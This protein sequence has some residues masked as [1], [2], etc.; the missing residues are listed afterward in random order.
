[1]MASKYSWSRSLAFP[2]CVCLL[3]YAIS[4]QA[5]QD[6]G[7]RQARPWPPVKW[8]N[9]SESTIADLDPCTFVFT[10]S[11]QGQSFVTEAIKLYR[12]LIFYGNPPC[13][14]SHETSKLESSVTELI[15]TAAQPIPGIAADKEHYVL[16]VP[17]GGSA[18]LV[19][20][21]YEGVLRGL[22]VFSQI[23][24]YASLEPHG[25]RSWHIANVPLQIEDS[26]DFGHRGLLID[27]ARTYLSVDT[28]KTVIDGMMYSKMN[29]LHIH[30][31]DSQAFPLEL[32]NN[33]EITYY[34]AMSEDKVY[35]QENIKGL[36]DYARLRGVRVYPEVN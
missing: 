17:A 3:F 5:Y 2:V 6:N 31:S 22:E 12:P 34:G 1:M 9:K 28:I 36:I 20:A 35:S 25:E 21:S 30:L 24:L 13:H 14:Q 26:P 7:Q 29:V 23:V 8:L 11:S 19:A 33:P 4:A 15:I 32:K 10:D 16:E 27:V 18:T